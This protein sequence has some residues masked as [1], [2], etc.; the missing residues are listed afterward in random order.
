MEAR[1]GNKNEA[2]RLY[3]KGLESCPG[4]A[5]LTSALASFHHKYFK[6][7]TRAREILRQGVEASPHEG[8]LWHTWAMVEKHAGDYDLA[9]ACTDESSDAVSTQLLQPLAILEAESG[10]M[11]RLQNFQGCHRDRSNGC[12]Y[13]DCMGQGS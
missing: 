12:T 4:D 13:V 9:T 8:V 6:N 3:E 11:R 1:E 2:L 5:A 7:V 10:A